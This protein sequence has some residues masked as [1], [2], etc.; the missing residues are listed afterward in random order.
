MLGYYDLWVQQER[1]Q[2]L[3]RQS[4]R[5]RLLHRICSN[6]QHSHGLH[7]RL[8]SWLGNRLVAWGH[9]LQER[10]GAAAAAS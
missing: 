10:Y 3:L 4:Q 1:S 9:S 5:E 6:S 7:C 8:L 2:E